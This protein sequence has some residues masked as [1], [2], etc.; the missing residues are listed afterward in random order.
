MH[1]NNLMKFIRTEAT[2]FNDMALFSSEDFVGVN[3]SSEDIFLFSSHIS[4]LYSEI[5]EKVLSNL[6]REITG[7]PFSQES[8][9]VVLRRAIV[10]ITHFFWE[11]VLRIQKIIAVNPNVVIYKEKYRDF[12]FQTSDEFSAKVQDPIY[13]ESL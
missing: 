9:K 1:L 3:M 7:F 10:P 12:I 6:M 2:S 8:L 5:I 4:D 13:H 11:R